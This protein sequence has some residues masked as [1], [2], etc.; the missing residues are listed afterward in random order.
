MENKEIS[1]GIIIGFVLLS[2]AY[3]F[4]NGGDETKIVML[5]IVYFIMK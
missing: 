2:L 3:I 1:T 4:V 5:L